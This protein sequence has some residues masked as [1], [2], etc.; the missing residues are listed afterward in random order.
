[1]NAG[2][3]TE[4]PKKVSAFDQQQNKNLLFNFQFFSI[5]SKTYP[6]VD[7]ETKTVKIR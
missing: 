7:F 3:N 4:C 6:N 2:K 5:L 1:M